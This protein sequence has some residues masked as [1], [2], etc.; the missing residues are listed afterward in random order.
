MVEII[1]ILK[2][3]VFCKTA[4]RQGEN[5]PVSRQVF[6]GAVWFHE[7]PDTFIAISG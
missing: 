1:T 3:Q 2:V 7:E 5:H 4:Y 6:C